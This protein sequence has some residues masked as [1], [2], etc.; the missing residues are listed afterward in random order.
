MV[1]EFCNK[2]TLSDAIQ[3]GWL[4]SVRDGAPQPGELDLMRAL[5][6]AREVAGAME[7]LHSQSVLH[8]D[9]NGNNILLAGVPLA[10]EHSDHR[11]FAAK[12]ADFGL[13][14]ILT[15]ENEKIITRTHGTITHMAPEVITEATHSKAADVYSFGV[16]LY[17][18]L[19]GCKPYHGMHYAQIVSSITS[20]KL[21]QMLPQQAPDLPSGLLELVA[22]CLATKPVDRPTFIELHMKL[23]ELEEQLAAEQ[24]LMLGQQQQVMAEPPQPQPQPQPLQVGNGCSSATAAAA[25]AEAAAAVAA[26]AGGNACG[27]SEQTRA[28][29]AVVGLQ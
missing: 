7:Y 21:L 8:G 1:L 18:L 13:S 12:V 4:L 24:Q 5:A 3:R 20:G 23:R 14:R 28:Q 22:A 26:Q 17:E 2:G 10:P 11:G 9:L 27:C 16:V 19:S 6:T 29:A 15:P 25:A